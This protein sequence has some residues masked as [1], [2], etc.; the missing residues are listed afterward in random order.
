MEER[1]VRCAGRRR[2]EPGRATDADD[3]D[4]PDAPAR[5][6]RP[7]AAGCATAS[8]SGSRPPRTAS[9]SGRSRWPPGLDVWQ[10]CFLSL[11]MFTGGSQFAL[12]GVLATRRRRPRAARRSPT[13]ALLGI[14]NVVY[15]MRM[16][17][18]VDR[19]GLAAARSPRRGSRSTSRP[20]SRSRRPSD[21]AARVGFWVDRARHL[22][23]LEPHDARGRAHRR[24]ARRH[25]GPGAWMPR[26]R[27][28]SSG[29]SGRG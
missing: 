28:P 7:D 17:P 1:V 27:P 29:C 13:A 22:R 20:R 4:A 5:R 2:D 6:R 9:R 21:R 23:R 24:R 14:R 12:V 3:A 10:T 19:G 26:R 18:I 8:A 15:G 11:V 25:A 16:K